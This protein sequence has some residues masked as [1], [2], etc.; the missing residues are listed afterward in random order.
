MKFSLKT[1]K[2]AWSQAFVGSSQPWAPL[3]WRWGVWA[4]KA[5]I[6]SSRKLVMSKDDELGC[7]T[8]K[9]G[10]SAR[11]REFGAGR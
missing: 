3:H 2:I 6:N 1:N 7:L 11:I 10:P 8:P 9:P 5:H 4:E